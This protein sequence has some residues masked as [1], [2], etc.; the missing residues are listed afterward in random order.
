VSIH[1]ASDEIASQKFEESPRL[2]YVATSSLSKVVNLSLFEA[3]EMNRLDVIKEKLQMSPLD[4]TKTDVSG[5]T[6]LIKACEDGFEG[7]IKY[8][9]DNSDELISMDT[10]LGY[11]PVHV[12]TEGNKLDCLK[13]L[14]DYGASLQSKTNLGNTPLHLA[15]EK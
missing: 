2:D 8:L 7:I 1:N 4:I 9:A 14:Y 3:V 13:I 5:R 12:C 15:S 10:P 11:F 6:L